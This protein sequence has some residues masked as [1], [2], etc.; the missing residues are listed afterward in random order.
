MNLGSQVFLSGVLI[1]MVSVPAV[2]QS[3]KDWVDIKN[4][5]E[6]RALHSNKTFRGKSSYGPFVV[7]YRVDGKGLLI[8]SNGERIPRT[9][10]IKGDQVC[11]TDAKA[12]DCFQYQR[13]KKNRNDIVAQNVR[14]RRAFL[15]T[16]EDGVPQF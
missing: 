14:D 3:S 1:C 6:L 15:L 13:H 5:K 11:V 8:N 2:A 9:W 7:H 10:E 4:P 12:T 16:V